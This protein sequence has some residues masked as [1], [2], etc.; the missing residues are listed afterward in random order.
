MKLSKFA[1]MVIGLLVSA[2]SMALTP[3]LHSIDAFKVITIEGEDMPS[4]LDLRGD[5]KSL[6]AMR[7]QPW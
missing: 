2:Q 3:P 4:A 7:A 1:A 5:Q 6:S